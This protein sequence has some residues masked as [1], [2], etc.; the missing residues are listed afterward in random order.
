MSGENPD[1]LETIRDNRE[2]C[3]AGLA[4]IPGVRIAGLCY[5]VTYYEHWLA[6]LIGVP[7]P[8]VR[9]VGARGACPAIA[10]GDGGSRRGLS[11]NSFC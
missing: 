6:R 3:L 4:S 10:S 8:E 1:L 11:A 2:A 5:G 9:C 7:W